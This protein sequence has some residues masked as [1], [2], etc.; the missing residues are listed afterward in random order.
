MTHIPN[1]K[2]IYISTTEED[3]NSRLDVVIARHI[4]DISREQIKQ[5][6]KQ[7]AVS[8]DDT[9]CT[10]P[11]QKITTHPL[12]I[13]V[14]VTFNE[15]KSSKLIESPIA[16][17]IKYEDEH[18]MVISKPKNM[19]S[20]PGAGT[21]QHTVASALL[22]HC[23]DSLQDITCCEP[24]RR[25]I[26]HRLDKDTTGLMVLAKNNK[27]HLLLSEAIRHHDIDRKYKTIVYGIPNPT[28]GQ[29]DLPIAKDK[30]NFK[31]MAIAIGMAGKEALTHY[32]TI[33]VIGNGVMSV[34]ECI[35]E[36]GRTHQ[37]RLHMQQIGCPVVGDR[38]YTPR[39]NITIQ[40]P[41]LQEAVDSLGRQA[42]HSY[43]ISFMHPIT[44]ENITIEE[45]IPEDMQ[46]I[47]SSVQKTLFS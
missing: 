44:K 32:N 35:L 29:V 19:S 28:A 17:N 45:P 11:S 12:T 31:K 24:E 14:C 47:I 36:T 26:V 9:P 7:G 20:H 43:H 30:K 34:V 10:K 27:T 42:L 41:T 16:L 22:H 5:L 13:K 40:N 37:I 1:S 2:E 23:G 3:I 33:Q 46:N 38:T 21:T 39:N 25:G 4:T 18:L 15:R 6:F 8:C